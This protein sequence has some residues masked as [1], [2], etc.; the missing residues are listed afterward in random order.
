MHHSFH[1]NNQTILKTVFMRAMT[2]SELFPL[3][4]LLQILK[5]EEFQWTE[6]DELLVSH[7]NTSAVQ[8]DRWLRYVI[9]N[10]PIF[11]LI[12]K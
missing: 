10:M 7:Y 11:G 9:C 6:L 1:D 2:S 5:F 3:K 4:V 12:T 8:K